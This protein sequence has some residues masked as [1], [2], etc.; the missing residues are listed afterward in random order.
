MQPN[1]LGEGLQELPSHAGRPVDR[2]I[3]RLDLIG[4][5]LARYTKLFAQRFHVA[6]ERV[7]TDLVEHLDEVSVEVHTVQV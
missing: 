1:R 7:V 3:L 5:Q 2:I 6:E 4:E